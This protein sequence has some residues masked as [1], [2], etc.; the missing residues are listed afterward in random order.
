MK[1]IG[2]VGTGQRSSNLWLSV[3]IFENS[4][5]A[6]LRLL[7][8][9]RRSGYSS[10][11]AS[12]WGSMEYK[13]RFPGDNRDPA[14]WRTHLQVGLILIFFRLTLDLMLKKLP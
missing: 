4:Y 5:S 6:C 13:F 3:L 9:R 10:G 11:I 1:R 8:R 2:R 14:R 7:S 12:N